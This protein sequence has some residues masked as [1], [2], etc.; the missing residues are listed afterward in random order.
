[1]TSPLVILV[2]GLF[3][4]P[5]DDDDWDNAAAKLV[6]AT[7][8]ECFTLQYWAGVILGKLAHPFRVRRLVKLLIANRQRHIT[9]IAHSNGC[10]IAVDA[11]RHRDVM[12]EVLALVAAACDSNFVANGLNDAIRD[13]RVNQILVFKSRKD[14]A[15][16]LAKRTAPWLDRVGLD[17]G[18]LGLE[19]PRYLV[20]MFAWRVTVTDKPIGHSDW[21][22]PAHIE[23][24]LDSIFNAQV[25]L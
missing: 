12:V 23:S 15:L 17:Y 2:P 7:S 21:L 25:K 13:T 24:T 19:G 5:R 6:R 8:R 3:T 1:M 10:R 14:G 11:L 9:I 4:C 18:W 20:G 16:A 22:A